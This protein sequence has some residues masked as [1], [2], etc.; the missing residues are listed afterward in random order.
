MLM[1]LGEGGS[2]FGRFLSPF[3]LSFFSFLFFFGLVWFGLR[4]FEG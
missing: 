3:F 4:E 2:E 1:L